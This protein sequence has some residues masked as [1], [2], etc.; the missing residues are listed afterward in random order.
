MSDIS[1]FGWKM[2]GAGGKSGQDILAA[3]R[4][5]V[6]GAFDDPNLQLEALKAAD[7]VFWSYD[8]TRK[9]FEFKGD[10]GALDLPPLWGRIFIDE[11]IPLFERGEVDRLEA[12]LGALDVHTA[13]PESGHMHC[14]LRLKDHRLVYLKGRKTGKTSVLGMMTDL[15]RDLS[16]QKR[17]PEAGIA[18]Q[19][20][21]TDALTGLHNRQGFLAAVRRMLAQPGDY[22]LVVGDLNRFRRLNEAL[23]HERADLVLIM[24][25]QRLRD[26]FGEGAILARLGEDEFAVLTQRGF[27]RISERMRTAIERPISVA[28]FDIHPTFSMGAVSI[29]GGDQALESAEI[30]RRAE[31]A[32]E[33]AKSKG[34]GGVASYRRDLESDGLSRLALEAELRKAF[35]SG[36]IHAWYQPIINLHTGGIS[37]FEALAR[38]IHPK[39]GVIAPD[40]FLGA[41][42]DLGL[43]VDLGAII[44]NTSVKLVEKWMKAY[45]L[46]EDFFV[47]VNLSAPEIERLNLVEDVSRLIREAGLPRKCLKLEVTESD[48]M[49][50]PQ[51][52]A[53]VLEAL[54]DAGAGIALDDFGTGFSSLSYL[55]KLPFDTLKIDRSFVNTMKSEMSSE[56]IVRS[57]LTLG[58]DLGLDVV[59]EGVEDMGL[60]DRLSALGCQMGQGWGFAKALTPAEAEAYLVAS[61]ENGD[62][63]SISV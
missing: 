13:S 37:G 23:G 28:G 56:K 11:L 49:R 54:R 2:G 34:A 32:V 45:S 24:L 21:H 27:P 25:A 52:S 33:A 55:A 62:M 50:D 51:A 19:D 7:S 12:A 42:R 6:H 14:L 31:L 63:R 43:M 40:H 41:T 17:R 59:A 20:V 48:V 57:I 44:L 46:P 36:E 58:R 1:L 5:D 35:V 38:W 15:S 4:M 22:D 8:L 61:L 47:S 39:R 29:E 9:R 30:L 18:V 10:L 16:L 26:A 53:R 3:A 60:A